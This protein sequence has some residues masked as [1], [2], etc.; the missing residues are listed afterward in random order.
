M[1]RVLR[2]ATTAAA[3][4][5]TGCTAGSTPP[6]STAV[7]PL[8][9]VLRLEL[10]GCGSMA[11]QRATA[12]VPAGL[13]LAVTVA[14]PFVDDDG[15]IDVSSLQIFDRAGTAVPGSLVWLDTERDLALLELEPDL[16]GLTL[17]EWMPGDDVA[18]AGFDSVDE[19]A[20]LRP[21]TVERRV[22]V[23]L[24]GEGARQALELTG[25]IE[26]GDSG[27]PL[28][29]DDLEVV[30]V[31]FAASRSREGGWAIDATEVQMLADVEPTTID[32]GCPT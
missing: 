26:P 32:L 18:M 5:A 22:E 8:D 10:D 31:V 27:A 1:A 30:G 15:A 9:S 17:G 24:D 12:V 21:L 3:L 13:G 11:R 25:I 29:D 19:P 7:D 28:I 14:H 20:R 4:L 16:P 6:E 2:R 23:T